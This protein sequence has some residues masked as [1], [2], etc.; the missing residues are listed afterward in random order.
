MAQD[1]ADDRAWLLGPPGPGQV[2]IHVQVGPDTELNESQRAAVEEL[3]ASFYE[4]EVEGYAM[5]Q[6]CRPLHCRPRLTNCARDY[7]GDFSCE[8]SRTGL[9]G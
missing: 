7:C 4:S 9:M 6:A 1:S 3:V 5:V 2:Q 8:V